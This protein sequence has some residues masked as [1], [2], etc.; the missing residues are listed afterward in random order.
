MKKQCDNKI[1]YCQLLLGRDLTDSE[2]ELV[3][4]ALDGKVSG[5]TL[6]FLDNIYD[7]IEYLK[8]EIMM[9]NLN[10]DCA[11]HR[12]KLAKKI[13][14]RRFAEELIRTAKGLAKK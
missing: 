8:E 5:K 12:I 4:L 9:N 13:Q 7:Y 2:V 11:E 3:Y 10:E 6:S 1:D 14:E